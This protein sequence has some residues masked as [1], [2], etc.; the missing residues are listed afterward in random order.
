VFCVLEDSLKLI[1]DGNLFYIAATRPSGKC[2]EAQPW[3]LN[4]LA[5]NISPT[6]MLRV[7]VL[8]TDGRPHRDSYSTKCPHKMSDLAKILPST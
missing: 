6:D 1:F 8:A 2:S 7:T 3:T 4:T 5:H